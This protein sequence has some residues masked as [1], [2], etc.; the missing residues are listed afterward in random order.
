MA[1]VAG[2]VF[3]TAVLLLGRAG[4]LLRVVPVDDFAAVVLVVFMNEGV[5]DGVPLTPFTGRFGGTVVFGAASSPFAAGGS[6]IEG[7]SSVEAIAVLAY[8]I[9]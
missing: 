7:M 5:L 4:G 8:K 6:T 3:R 1:V 9:D 2:A